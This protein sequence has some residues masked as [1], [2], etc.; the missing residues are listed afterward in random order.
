MRIM[1]KAGSADEYVKV[2]HT[3]VMC[4]ILLK[5]RPENNS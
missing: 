5:A 2:V 1:P 4:D 3:Q